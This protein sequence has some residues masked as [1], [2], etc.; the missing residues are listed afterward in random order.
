MTDEQRIKVNVIVD[1]LY[2][3]TKA[4][5]CDWRQPSH[6]VNSYVLKFKIGGQIRIHGS[7]K[8]ITLKIYNDDMVEIESLDYELILKNT[9]VVKLFDHVKAYHADRIAKILDELLKDLD[10]LTKDDDEPS[11][12]EVLKNNKSFWDR[13]K[14]K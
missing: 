2:T 8:K 7:E 12:P 4:G 13:L 6:N 10:E 3:A 9:T 11:I 5:K 14:R 1:K